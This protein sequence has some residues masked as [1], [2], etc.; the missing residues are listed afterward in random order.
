MNEKE[1][2][3]LERLAKAAMEHNPQDSED[4]LERAVLER[5]D[6]MWQTI[7]TKARRRVR[8][9]KVRP[10]IAAAAVVMMA[11][12]VSGAIGV[13]QARA[14]KE[15]LLVDIVEGVA[16][17][18]N[19]T[20]SNEPVETAEQGELDTIQLSDA[21][22]DEIQDNVDTSIQHLLPENNFGTYEFINGAYSQLNN[23]YI[24]MWLIYK[25]ISD[26]NIITIEY[27]YRGADMDMSTGNYDVSDSES[28]HV[29]I[30]DWDGVTMYIVSDD[31]KTTAIWFQD[32]C[33]ISISGQ[34]KT[35]Q[36]KEIYNN[37]AR[38]P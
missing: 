29:D 21:T 31:E 8:M 14:G 35:E 25:D 19:V 27:A 33:K 23:D 20:F 34:I 9:R 17:D 13:N 15:G 3:E 11:V 22:W 2:K 36:I 16:G 18:I 1:L 10:W 12:I 37:I 4:M 5:K 28:S 26:D 6:E 24:D 7:Q 32:K 38:E 30:K